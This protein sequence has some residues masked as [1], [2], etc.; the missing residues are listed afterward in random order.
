[1]KEPRKRRPRHS[2]KTSKPGATP[3]MTG[4]KRPPAAARGPHLTRQA[5]PL[6][7]ARC[8]RAGA[9]PLGERH[10]I[11]TLEVAALAEG[12]CGAAAAPEGRGPGAAKARN[13]ARREPRSGLAPPRS[14]G[15]LRRG[16][17]AAGATTRLAARRPRTREESLAAER[18]GALGPGRDG[19]RFGGSSSDKAHQQTPSGPRARQ[20]ARC[21]RDADARV[22]VIRAASAGP[23]PCR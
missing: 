13:L 8:G 12:R 10:D 21:V 16:G 9:H 7:A 3:A 14:A 11:R 22:G 4:A 20:A 19:P 15:H 23:S 5:R 17:S 1:M 18:S 6:R 2:R